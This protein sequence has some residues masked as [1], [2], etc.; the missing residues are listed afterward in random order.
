MALRALT[1]LAQWA[2]IRAM[3]TLHD[4]L[5]ERRGRAKALADHLHLQPSMVTKM[6]S[7]EKKI[8]LDHC[9]HIESFTGGEVSCEAQ[10][11]DKVEYFAMLRQRPIHQGEGVHA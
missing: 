10:R 2:I 8:P 9:P 7:G 4:W 5:A 1:C 3:K 11:P 6:A